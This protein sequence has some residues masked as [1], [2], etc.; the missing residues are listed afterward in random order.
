MG[1]GNLSTSDGQNMR[2]DLDHGRL[3]DDPRLRDADAR[4]LVGNRD[5][6]VSR[7]LYISG[8][9]HTAHI[10]LVCSVGN[11]SGI[12]EEGPAPIAYRQRRPRAAIVH[13]DLCAGDTGSGITG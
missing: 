4:A 1:D 2:G 3:P 10:N 13:R 6:D 11:L 12:P 7:V 5:R 9:I 8:Y